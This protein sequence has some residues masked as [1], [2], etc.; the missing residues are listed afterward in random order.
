M[1][2]IPAENA[3]WERLLGAFSKGVLL[4]KLNFATKKKE[5]PRV[6]SFDCLPSR[7]NQK[8]SSFIEEGAGWQSAVVHASADH[9]GMT[10]SENRSSL[11][12][13]KSIQGCSF[14][15]LPHGE[16]I[17]ITN[18]AFFSLGTTGNHTNS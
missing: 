16:G 14:W 7:R 2:Q 5:F 3:Y 8:P 13:L 10:W 6:V 18:L 4:L 11:G 12:S 9:Y 1:K 15:G 17:T